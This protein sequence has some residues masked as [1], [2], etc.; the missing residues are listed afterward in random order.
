MIYKVLHG[1]APSYLRDLINVYV[2]SRQLRSAHLQ[3][4]IVPKSKSVQYSDRAFSVIGPTLW[5]ELPHHIKQLR[6]LVVLK[7]L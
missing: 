7:H 3:M 4:L 6:H 1:M 2:P 5:N